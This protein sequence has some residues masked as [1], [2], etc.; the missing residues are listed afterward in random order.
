[1]FAI[2]S[3]FSAVASVVVVVM[4]VAAAVL[5][6]QLAFAIGYRAYSVV[7]LKS[8]KK[9]DNWCKDIWLN[10]SKH[11][12]LYGKVWFLLSMIT[13]LTVVALYTDAVKANDVQV[14]GTLTAWVF[15]GQTLI[16]NFVG[17]VIKKFATAKA[18]K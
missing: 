17:S 1:M 12:T 14:L 8:S 11:G 6:A 7:T 4:A 10:P 9:L 16:V 5:V 3:V 15:V 18:T 2:S 13:M